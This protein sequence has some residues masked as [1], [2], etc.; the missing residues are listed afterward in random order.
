MT[1]KVVV[2]RLRIAAILLTLLV[3]AV[4]AGGPYLLKHRIMNNE[5]TALLSLKKI[6]SIENAYME[7]D[8]TVE[9][10]CGWSSSNAQNDRREQ[11]QLRAVFEEAL[12]HDY[13]LEFRNC[14]QLGYRV[15]A[16][17]IHSGPI[18]PYTFCSD[19]T[20]VIHFAASPLTCDASSPIWT[21]RRPLN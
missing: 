15:V 16:N 3:A 8:H 7:R 14:S 20:A 18:A 5:S 1:E 10:A 13:Q 11:M 19:Q 9:P 21:D 6:I 12:K 4:L 2:A 17:P